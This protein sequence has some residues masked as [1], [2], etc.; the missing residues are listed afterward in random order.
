MKI[1]D[2]KDPKFIS[3]FFSPDNIDITDEKKHSKKYK[4]RILLKY[5]TIII[6]QRNNHYYILD[7]EKTIEKYNF[8]KKFIK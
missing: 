6:Y 8:L 3:V 5:N 7:N 1:Y 4:K 2:E